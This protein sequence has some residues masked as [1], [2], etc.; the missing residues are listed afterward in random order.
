MYIRCRGCI[1]FK[2]KLPLKYPSSELASVTGGDKLEL[3]GWSADEVSPSR[4]NKIVA[5]FLYPS[6]ENLHSL[7]GS[8]S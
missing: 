8:K 2:T 3:I 4:H 6:T 5:S 1:N 7:L